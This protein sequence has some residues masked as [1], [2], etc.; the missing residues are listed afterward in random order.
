MY[1]VKIASHKADTKVLGKPVTRLEDLPLVKGQGR[2][3]ADLSFPHQLHMRVVRSEL[4]NGIISSIDTAAALAAPGVV[5]VWTHRDVS[6]YP[7]I[8]FRDPSAAAL[9]PYKQPIL[10]KER[11]R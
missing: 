1:E 5:A 2:Y 6:A 7:A 10:A 11:V 8:D 9:A 3:V 4:A